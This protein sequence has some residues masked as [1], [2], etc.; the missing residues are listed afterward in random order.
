MNNK[1]S[2]CSNFVTWKALVEKQTGKQLEA[3]GYDNGG[4]FVST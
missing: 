3:L 1:S 4:E 2:C